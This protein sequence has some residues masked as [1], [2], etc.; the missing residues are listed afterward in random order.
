MHCAPTVRGLTLLVTLAF[1]IIG[2]QPDAPGDPPAPGHTEADDYAQDAYAAESG[3]ETSSPITPVAGVS[4]SDIAGEWVGEME[5]GGEWAEIDMRIRENGTAEGQWVPDGPPIRYT[6]SL[7]D[8][9]GNPMVTLQDVDLGTTVEGVFQRAERA[10]I[11]G[12][13]L[14]LY[15]R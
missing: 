13:S 6:W 7:R 4:A 14:S 3:S 15:R 12:D 9:D 11:V 5:G 1:L 10:E 8:A 2:C